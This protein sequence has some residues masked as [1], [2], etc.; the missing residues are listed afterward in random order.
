[1]HIS[2]LHIYEPIHCMHISYLHI[3]APIHCM[4]IS[5]VHMYMNK[6]NFSNLAQYQH[7]YSLSLWKDKEYLQVRSLPILQYTGQ[8]FLTMTTWDIFHLLRTTSLPWIEVLL[9]HFGPVHQGVC[10]TF[11][12]LGNLQVGVRLGWEGESK[13]CVIEKSFIMCG[14]SWQCMHPVCLQCTIHRVQPTKVLTRKCR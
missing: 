1:M 7:W 2:Y 3:Y 12:G 8:P 5:Y 4:H 14:H 9:N 11:L 10:T 13:A 6:H